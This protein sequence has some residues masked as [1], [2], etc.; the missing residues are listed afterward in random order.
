[1]PRPALCLVVSSRLVFDLD[2][3]EGLGFDAVVR[4]AFEFRELLTQ[5]GLVTFRWYPEARACL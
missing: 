3:D 1:M 5:I 4:A 2:P